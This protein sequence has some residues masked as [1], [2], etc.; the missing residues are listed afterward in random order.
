MKWSIARSN[1]VKKAIASDPKLMKKL[2]TATD[3]VF[4]K[5]GLKFGNVSYVFEPRVFVMD[6]KKAPNALM[7]G[8]EAMVKTMVGS[9]R[10]RGIIPRDAFDIGDFRDISKYFRCIPE[11]GGMDP[12]TLRVIE[13]L[14]VFD[15]SNPLP[16]SVKIVDS[17]GLMSSI[18]GNKALMKDFS[19][20]IFGALSESGIKLKKNEGCV[21][22]P[23]VAETPVFA[24][25]IGRAR[26]MTQL[27]G[28]GPQVV[29]GPS[30]EVNYQLK[31]RPLPGIIDTNWGATPGII[32]RWWW[33]IG[34]PAP[35][36]LRAMDLIR[37]FQAPN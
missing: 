30:M 24:Q 21:F 2:S 5:H 27:T 22:T 16:P 3:K 1:E 17:E 11:C 37:D 18:V 25:K 28:F 23:F 26:G 7:K 14:R 34:I 15:D 4:K 33:W 9:L 13:F 12:Y 10:T 8:R 19:K 29:A 36:F 20:T 31:I 35:E 32:V 6:S